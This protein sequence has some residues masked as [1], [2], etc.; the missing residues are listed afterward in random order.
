MNFPFQRIHIYEYKTLLGN[1]FLLT[2]EDI[3]DMKDEKKGVLC[4]IFD[5]SPQKLRDYNFTFDIKS[6]EIKFFNYDFLNIEEKENLE[7]EINKY[8]KRVNS[9]K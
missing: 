5:I 8:Y 9:L 1:H 3:R 6:K 2:K 7:E 4:K